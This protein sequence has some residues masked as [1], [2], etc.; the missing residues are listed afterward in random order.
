MPG[1]LTLS[2]ISTNELRDMNNNVMMSDGALTGN[3]V[4][5]AGHVIQTVYSFN[6][7]HGQSTGTQYLYDNN[8]SNTSTTG[9]PLTSI[10]TKQNNT[11]LMVTLDYF[12]ESGE[13]TT[14]GFVTLQSHLRYSTDSVLT[15]ATEVLIHYMMNDTRAGG[16]LPQQTFNNIH[17]LRPLQLSNTKNDVYYFGIK[18]VPGSTN[19]GTDYYN[20][21]LPM[22]LKIEEI[23]L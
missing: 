13:H 11:L 3:V 7:P 5:P 16:D 1:S 2:Q 14:N 23:S 6:T 22:V 20:G 9:T 21:T 17:V 19:M 8:V 15:N 18:L 4:F 10:T 12:Y